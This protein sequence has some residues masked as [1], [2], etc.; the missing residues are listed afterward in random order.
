MKI[1]YVHFRPAKTEAQTKAINEKVKLIKEV[2][3]KRYILLVN[4]PKT[5]KSIYIDGANK[6]IKR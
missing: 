2:S 6:E 5:L 1:L 3:V 4:C